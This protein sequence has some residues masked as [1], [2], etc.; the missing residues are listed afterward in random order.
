MRRPSRGLAGRAYGRPRIKQQE[1]R[2]IPWQ[3]RQA[4]SADPNADCDAKSGRQ[5]LCRL[6][7]LNPICVKKVS[8]ATLWRVNLEA[9]VQGNL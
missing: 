9:R 7:D 1:S 2:W 5:C 3:A 4:I 6:A 8:D